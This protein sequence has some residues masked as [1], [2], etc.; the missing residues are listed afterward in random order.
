[1]GLL[2]TLLMN[3]R[4]SLALGMMALVAFSVSLSTA[5]TLSHLIQIAKW[6]LSLV[7]LN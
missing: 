1:M 2:Q 4:P 3:T 5:A 7:H 6:V